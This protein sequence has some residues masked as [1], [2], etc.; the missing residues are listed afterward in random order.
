[1]YVWCVFA[2]TEVAIIAGTLVLLCVQQ[3]GFVGGL[4]LLLAQASF[5]YHIGY[6]NVIHIAWACVS[7]DVRQESASMAWARA[8]YALAQDLSPGDRIITGM[9]EYGANYVAM[10]QVRFYLGLS[11]TKQVHTTS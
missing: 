5:A 4:R 3:A 7:P 1:M 8:F 11:T 9:V 6:M 2:D 10:L